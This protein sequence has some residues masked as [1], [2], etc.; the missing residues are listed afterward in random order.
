MRKRKGNVL[1]KHYLR[2]C[3]KEHSK[4]LKQLKFYKDE[5]DNN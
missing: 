4:I 2:A 3:T 1:M 5:N